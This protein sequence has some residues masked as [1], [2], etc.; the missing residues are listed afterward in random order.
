MSIA[1]RAFHIQALICPIWLAGI[2]AFAGEIPK[3]PQKISIDA[4]LSK[5]GETLEGTIAIQIVNDTHAPLDS[6]PLWLYPNRFEKV[7]EALGDR[8][9][10]WIYPSGESRGGIK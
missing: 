1:V 7:S 10:R 2:A 9:V 4:R 8:M 6:I 5:G 3:Q